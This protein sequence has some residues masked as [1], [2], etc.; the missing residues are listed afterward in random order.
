MAITKKQ[1]KKWNE[2]FKK[3]SKPEKKILIAK[4]VLAN[5]KSKKY[6]PERRNYVN[7]ISDNYNGD[8]DV[9]KNFDKIE[10][11]ECCALGACLISSTKYQNKLTFDDLKYARSHTDNSWKQLEKIFTP[12]EMAIMEYC[13]EGDGGSKVAEDTF[14][15]VLDTN[16]IQK[17]EGFYYQHNSPNERLTAI[18]NNIIKNKGFI[19][20]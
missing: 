1:I 14:S 6:Q 4:D 13:F 17:C 20:I 11:C 7:Y 10:N 9:Q 12:R 2:T 16:T 5:I 8:D 15:Y 3:A 18:C 19:K